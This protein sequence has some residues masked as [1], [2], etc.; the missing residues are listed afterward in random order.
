MIGSAPRIAFTIGEPAGIGPDIAI[1][2]AQNPPACKI[3]V[4]G[5]PDLIAE[6]AELLKMPLRIEPWREQVTTSGTMAVLAE[7]LPASV[8]PGRLNSRNAESVLR[9][10]NRAVDGCLDGHFD[11]MATG[12]V[13]KGVINTAGISFSGHTEYISER[14]G[15]PSPVMMLTT[16][17]TRVALVTTHIPLHRVCNE[18]TQERLYRVLQVVIDDMRGKFDIDSPRI[19]VCGLNPHAGEQGHM[20]REEIEIISP[21]I[22]GVQQQGVR[23]FG[24]LP[25]DTV[26]VPEIQLQFD[27]ILSM[28]HDQGLPV[29]KHQGFDRA[30]NITLGIPI[31]RTSV[32][33]GTA[34]DRVGHA[35]VNAGSALA[36]LELAAHLAQLKLD[37]MRVL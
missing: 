9:C 15:S 10:I 34:L 26:F 27:V 36:A 29:I 17:D 18:I 14:T 2:V 31:I 25:A 7:P 24:P 1:R 30:V 5:D 16:G 8:E 3:A 12:P 33:H 11:A 32:D 6:R 22:E 28:Y 35:N 23:I 21:V 13:H 37:S 20:G 19:A 4:I